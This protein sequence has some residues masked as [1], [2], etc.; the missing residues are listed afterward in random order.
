MTKV[1]RSRSVRRNHSVRC[2]HSVILHPL[3]DDYLAHL[4]LR[5]K[6]R[7]AVNRQ[8]SLRDLAPWMSK[9]GIDPLRA[10]TQQLQAYQQHLATDYRSAAGQPLSRRSQQN[11]IGA[12]KAWYHWLEQRGCVVV[13]PSR[14]LHLRVLKSRVVVSE[15]LTLQEATAVVQTQ[16]HTV[17]AETTGSHR[18]AI[19]MRNLALVCLA[20]A[21]GRR[22]SGLIDFTVAD[23]DCDQCE[24]RVEREKS[25]MGRVL[26]AASW[27]MD[28][29]RLYVTTA[30]PLLVRETDVPWLFVDRH[31][32]NQPTTTMLWFVLQNIIARTMAQNPDLDALPRKHITWHTFRVSFA[33]LLFAN[34]CDI[35]SINELMLH[36]LLSTTA[37]YTP[38]GLDDMR[39]VVRTSHPRGRAC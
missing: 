19:E 11:R 28:V 20:L 6:I 4:E 5:N 35:R 39:H 16:A 14:S 38:L 32:T 3:M 24:V 18:W 17:N 12:V 2:N 37:Q 31:G 25:Q 9:N 27:A 21:T 23:V 26:P 7:T 30:R 8:T 34:G 10:T 15:P 36:R 33:T 22:R 29:V 13:D 1:R